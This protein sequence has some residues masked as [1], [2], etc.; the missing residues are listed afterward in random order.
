[1]TRFSE[2]PP[3]KN[4]L[5]GP[6]EI[7]TRWSTH[8]PPWVFVYDDHSIL[9]GRGTWPRMG[10]WEMNREWMRRCARVS[11]ASC[12][13]NQQIHLPYPDD[14][15]NSD[16]FPVAPPFLQRTSHS[17]LTQSVCQVVLQKSI[18]PQIQQLIPYITHTKNMLS[19][20][21]GNRLLQNDFMKTF[22]ET[23]WQRDMPCFATVPRPRCEHGTWS[24]RL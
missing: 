6:V 12:F 21:W 7:L 16:V 24:R 13:C 1:M 11:Q 14:S 3:L 10:L 4:V 2:R 17:Y 18:P 22:C 23:N 9:R 5:K 19:G 20:L 8:W 15:L